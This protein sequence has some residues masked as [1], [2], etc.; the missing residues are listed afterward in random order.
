[1]IEELNKIIHSKPGEL[2]ETEYFYLF[3]K[4][5]PVEKK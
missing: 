1:M 5:L 3:S 4:P 2:T